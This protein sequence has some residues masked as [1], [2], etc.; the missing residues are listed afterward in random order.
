MPAFTRKDFAEWFPQA[1]PEAR[2]VMGK[3]LSL[4]PSERL[5]C[6]QCLEHPYF[7]A[8]HDPDDEPTAKPFD[9]GYTGDGSD[10][11]VEQLKAL[12]FN[13]IKSFVY[14]PPQDDSMDQ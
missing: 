1:T 8:Y 7:T 6:A 13:E 12:M 11:T 10:L 5:S 2:D 4:D 9:E 14:T 3:M